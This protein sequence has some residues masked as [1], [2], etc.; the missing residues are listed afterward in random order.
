MTP[1]PTTSDRSARLVRGLSRDLSRSRNSYIAASQSVLDRDHTR[2]SDLDTK[3]SSEFDPGS[4][5]IFMSTRQLDDTAK[6]LP[7]IR[8]TAKKFAYYN[9]PQPEPRVDTSMLEQE[10]QDFDQDISLGEESMSIEVGRGVRRSTRNTPNKFNQSSI[11]S[12]NQQVSI[13]DD[14]LY[15]VTGT[16]GNRPRLTARNTDGGERSNLR[17]E[18]QIRRA[19]SLPQKDIDTSLSRL[20]RPG[21]RVS[22]GKSRRSGLA[23]MHAK[24]TSEESLLD[25][26]PP[27]LT[28]SVKN[29]RFG[30]PRSRQS[31]AGPN[32]LSSKFTSD[33]GLNTTPQRAAIGTPR[34]ATA[35]ATQ[36]SFMLPD[37]P[38]LTELVSG[39]Y[40]D[41]T[42]V[43]SRGAKARSR[44]TSGSYPN[45]AYNGQPGHLPVES[46]PVPADEKAIFASLQLL[47]EKVAQLEQEK[48]E[49]ERRIEDYGNEV[50]GLKVEL[51]MQ[52]NMRRSDSALGSTDGEGQSSKDNWRVEK[53]SK[54][55]STIIDPRL[56]RANR[57]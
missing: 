52:Q 40:K 28:T 38:N 3:S 51:E 17:K 5:E 16:P 2:N 50:I 34:S 48:A 45:R 32:G 37:L 30:N 29:T 24:V 4:D 18:A 31:S 11:M 53:T 57:A 36:Q 21:T 14:S 10:F 7:H 46:I 55:T 20:G 8:S 47:R 13:G 41:G 19:A 33:Q 15:E 44:F 42:P 27:T 23:D 35:N 6:Q 56:T 12:P 49:S 43:F 25:E 22:P 26:R 9:P 1:S 54:C 39:V